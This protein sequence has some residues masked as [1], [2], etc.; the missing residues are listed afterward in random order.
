MRRNMDLIREL[1]LRL[2]AIELRSGS[3]MHIDATDPEVEIEG[4]G[5]DDIDYH[6]T[7]IHDAGLIS[8]SSMNPAIGIAFRGISWSGHDF[9]DTIRDPEIWAKTKNGATA[10]GGF[11]VELLRD[12]AKGFIKKQIEEYTGVKL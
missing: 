11:T 6:L 10:A 2:E 9:L 12:L 8:P 7:L 4:Y 1:L 3:V 5:P